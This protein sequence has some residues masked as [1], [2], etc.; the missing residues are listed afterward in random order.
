M[1]PEPLSLPLPKKPLGFRQGSRPRCHRCTLQWGK[2]VLGLAVLSLGLDGW[3]AEARS[4]NTEQF[5][6]DDAVWG[7]ALGDLCTLDLCPDSPTTDPMDF[8]PGSVPLRWAAPENLDPDLSLPTDKPALRDGADLLQPDSS[9]LPS[10]A[11][12][13][14]HATANPTAH[15]N[16]NPASSLILPVGDSPSAG[17]NRS[18]EVVMPS[19]IAS[20]GPE[21]RLDSAPAVLDAQTAPSP[22][23]Q[24]PREPFFTLENIQINQDD[25]F[26]KSGQ[27]SDLFEPIFQGRLR[28][29]T[30][31]QFA[32]GFNVY[33]E[34][35]FTKLINIPLHFGYEERIE[36]IPV[37]IVA[38]INFFNRLAPA[39][40]L[41]TK[42]TIPIGQRAVL[43]WALDYGPY[44]FNVE[45]L[46]NRISA[47]RYGPSLFWQIDDQTTLFTNVTWG[48]YS[49]SNR[50]QQ[51]FSRLEHHF[52]EEFSVAANLFNWRYRQAIGPDSGYFS[53]A[54]F[55]V[56]SVEAAWEKPIFSNFK[57]RLAGN[58][59]RQH[60]SGAWSA[61]YGYDAICTVGLNR[62]LEA[63]LGYSFSNVIDGSTGESAS[64]SREVR[65]KL[66]VKL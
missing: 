65:S 55:L 19:A 6:V 4:T 39:P 14:P 41:S 5:Q 54:D 13:T 9:P 37:D 58:L 59:G 25:N 35:K 36:G 63:D 47:F 49:D 34:P 50:D 61:A 7:E 17:L 27:S 11:H 33:D 48:R 38:G 56:Y 29:G 26:S 18:I 24:K 57:C 2:I 22:Q 45:T 46:E 15:S 28:D 8:G 43:S 21:A 62:Y 23:A 66:R 60:V 3:V 42:A 12:S 40:S 30:S 20:P 31:V 51:S 1:E 32:T 64:N 53:P 10:A 52:G 16:A 44:K